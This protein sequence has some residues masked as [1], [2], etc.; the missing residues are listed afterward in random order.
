MYRPAY[1]E[2]SKYAC[3]DKERSLNVLTVRRV[4]HSLKHVARIW[5]NT[6]KVE[7]KMIC[8]R[9]LEAAPSIFTMKD[10]LVVFYVDNLRI[11]AKHKSAI[12]E[13]N[14]Q[15]DKRF[16]TKDLRSPKQFLEIEHMWSVAGALQMNQVVLITRLLYETEICN[17][18][19][20][21]GPICLDGHGKE[22][23]II[24]DSFEQGQY[25]SITGSLLY[26]AVR[27]RP[28]IS[29]AASVRVAFVEHLKTI[30]MQATKPDL[31]YLKRT[32]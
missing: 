31:R 10:M 16:V 1:V 29:V 7:F 20:T 4:L 18:K 2:M 5:H 11:F 13:S 23:I 9:N 28:G 15:L 8:I 19:P 14:V 22:G 3:S 6:M 17:A 27:A 25:R 24:V 32:K 12:D 21:Q 26:L 30:H